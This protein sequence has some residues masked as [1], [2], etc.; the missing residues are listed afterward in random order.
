MGRDPVTILFVV[1]VLGFLSLGVGNGQWLILEPVLWLLGC[2]IDNLEWLILIPIF[3][4][5]SFWVRDASKLNPIFRLDIIRI[6]NFLV[7]IDGGGKVF[8]E[9]ARFGGGVIDEDFK[10][11]VRLDDQGI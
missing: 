9:A 3:G 1:P 7:G 8:Q 10:G 11:V 4:L 6:I 2:L 5:G